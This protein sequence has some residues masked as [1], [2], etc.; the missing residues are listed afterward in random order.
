MSKEV[1][2][3]CDGCGKQVNCEKSL[4]KLNLFIHIA[5]APALMQIACYK[6]VKI[7]SGELCQNCFLALQQ[8]LNKAVSD[9]GKK[10]DEQA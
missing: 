8:R 1:I 6:P 9:I 10:A 3:R 4:Y 2:Y 7:W 5:D